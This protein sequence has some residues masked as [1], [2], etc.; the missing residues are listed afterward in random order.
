MIRDLAAPNFM[1]MA[2]TEDMDDLLDTFMSSS[3]FELVL[4]E[5]IMFGYGNFLSKSRCLKQKVCASF[6]I[7]A[8]NLMERLIFSCNVI[9]RWLCNVRDGLNSGHCMVMALVTFIHM[10]FNCQ[11]C[12]MDSLENLLNTYIH[13]RKRLFLVSMSP[14]VV[15]I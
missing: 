9:E 4:T 2:C 14:S 5:C 8:S 15:L 13:T 12:F 6:T 3:G 7:S 1:A 10:L 11:S